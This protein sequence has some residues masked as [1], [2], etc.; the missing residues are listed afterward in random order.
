M[1]KLDEEHKKSDGDN[2]PWTIYAGDWSA[3]ELFGFLGQA[4][5]TFAT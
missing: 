2:R 5:A 3:L 1:T 4:V